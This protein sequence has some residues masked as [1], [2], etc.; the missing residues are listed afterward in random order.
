[1]DRKSKPV[2]ITSVDIDTIEKDEEFP[3]A[4]AFY[5][6]LSDKPDLL[7]ETYFAEW[8]KALSTMKRK[9][10]V[11]GDKLRLVFAYGDDIQNYVKFARGIVENTNERIKEH[12]RKVKLVEKEDLA[13]QEESR[14]KE[15]EIRQTLRELE[16]KPMPAAIEVSVEEFVSAYEADEGTADAK[17]V[18]K[19]LRVTGVVAMIDVKD[20]LDTHY[21]RLTGAERNLLQSVQCMFDKKHAPILKQ[22]EK[23]QTVT[24]Q[25]EYRGSIIAIRMIDCTLVQ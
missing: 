2:E 19:L 16:P 14:R 3:D 23:G 17:F 15:E 13:K 9:I 5:I 8:D 1:M 11:V 20:I 21:I 22:L 18:N 10:S 12:N 7:W 4:Y 6:K 24:V 25:G